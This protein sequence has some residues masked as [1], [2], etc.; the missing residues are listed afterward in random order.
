MKVA[1]CQINTTIGD[2]TGNQEKIINSILKAASSNA[3]L[4]VFPELV[5]SSYP[6]LDLLDRPDFID[7]NQFA[8]ELLLKHIK[9][10]KITLPYIILG[11]ITKNNSKSGRALFNS[12]VVIE[13]KAN[14]V[15]IIHTQSKR[16][17]PTYD[18]FDE[19]RY[20]EPAEK[21]HLWNSPF[22]KIGITI[23]EDAWYDDRPG[24]RQLYEK[25]PA[26]DLSDADIVINISASP[27]EMNK[28]EKRRKMLELFSQKTK[29]KLIYVNQVGAND[30]ILFDGTS[31]IY[32]EN[33]KRLHESPVF[34]E[35]IEVLDLE[36]L[37]PLNQS[38]VTPMATLHSALV[39]GI[40]D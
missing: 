14:K 35:S 40:K 30:E 20:F 3:D 29:A 7:A 34:E 4:A 11:T 17:L 28:Q 19:T 32:N 9:E 33:G 15:E 8:L 36:K 27:F 5:L 37:N 38:V 10:K 25:N 6:P 31:S 24:G 26:D 22:G 2:F 23:C 21:S 16:L 12:A 39:S 13:N 18:V 1:L